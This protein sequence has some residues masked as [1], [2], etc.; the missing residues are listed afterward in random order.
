MLAEKPAARSPCIPL[1]WRASYF[2]SMLRLLNDLFWIFASLWLALA[3][4]WLD[5]ALFS[6]CKALTCWHTALG[7]LCNAVKKAVRTHCSASLVQARSPKRRAGLGVHLRLPSAGRGLE[8]AGADV[9]ATRYQLPA[10]RDCSRR[11]SASAALQMLLILFCA[12][13]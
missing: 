7:L 4:L 2:F 12:G 3:S 6:V 1:E 9:S 11:Y 5:W 8:R 13:C 10:R